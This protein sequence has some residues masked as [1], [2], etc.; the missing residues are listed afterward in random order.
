MPIGESIIFR[1]GYVL[2]AVLRVI[3]DTNHPSGRVRHN[4]QRPRIGK[5]KGTQP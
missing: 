5:A 2:A 1:S 3:H 4:H